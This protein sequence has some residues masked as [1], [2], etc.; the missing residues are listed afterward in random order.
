[1]WR[2]WG[3]C[4]LLDPPLR[5]HRGGGSRGGGGGGLLDGFFGS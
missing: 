1:L 5:V 2:G 3:P 4:R